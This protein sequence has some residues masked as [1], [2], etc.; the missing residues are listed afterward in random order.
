MLYKI[1]FQF[2]KYLQKKNMHNSGDSKVEKMVCFDIGN[3]LIKLGKSTKE[4]FDIENEEELHFLLKCFSLG[5]IDSL[6]FLKKLQLIIK[7]KDLSIN[8]I[9]NIFIHKRIDHTH[10]GVLK[11]ILEL[12]EKGIRI[13]II[14]NTN[15]LH[16]SYLEKILPIESFE[17]ILL[18]HICQIEK[19]DKRIYQILEERTGLKNKEILFFDD[20]Q[21]NIYTASSLGW[22]ANKVPL[23]NPVDFMRKILND[24]KII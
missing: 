24:S 4:I 9:E 20:I 6:F 5:S 3:V 10:E 8:E 7:R 23:L 18:S 22:S 12:K 1:K 11:L 21:E 15:E 2:R 16:W 17:V 13:A 19:P 14:S